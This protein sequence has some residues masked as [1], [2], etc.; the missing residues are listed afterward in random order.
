MNRTFKNI[1]NEIQRL[2]DSEVTSYEVFKMT[3]VS[4]S[5]LDDLRRKTDD[6]RHKKIE[7]LSLKV[8][9]QLYSYA[10]KSLPR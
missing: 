8:A 5:T 10:K 7:N 9:E 4:R 6:K 3:G 2:I 1:H